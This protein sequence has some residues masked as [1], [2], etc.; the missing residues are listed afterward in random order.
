MLVEAVLAAGLLSTILGMA[1]CVQK[2]AVGGCGGRIHRAR[3]ALGEAG[4]VAGRRSGGG[5]GP[6]E[7]EAGRDALPGPAGPGWLGNGPPTHDRRRLS[8]DLRQ[9]PSR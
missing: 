5:T 8:P 3:R 7:D 4:S 2:P 6:E 1:S 9:L